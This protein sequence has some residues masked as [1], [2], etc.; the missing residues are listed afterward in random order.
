MVGER[1]SRD[2]YRELSTVYTHPDF[3]GRR[4][5]RQLVSRLVNVKLNE[6]NTPFL[7]VLPNNERARAVYESLG[8][9][10]RRRIPLIV[11]QHAD[12]VSKDR[13]TRE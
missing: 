3:Q 4:Y 10:E 8:F 6:G 1:M 7:H 11:V 9:V 5:A 12:G 2:G 13:V